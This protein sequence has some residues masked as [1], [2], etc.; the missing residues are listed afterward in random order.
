MN[1]STVGVL[2][3]AALLSASC[4]T[5]NGPQAYANAAAQDEACKATV[6]TNTAE[7]M[8]MQNQKGVQ[9]DEMKRTEGALAL[10]RIKQNEPAALRN[11]IAPE[12]SLASKTLRG[13]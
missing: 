2:G 11:P 10:A 5:L 4:E 8:R 1:A 7:S 3:L 6:V 9:T 12:E 13:C